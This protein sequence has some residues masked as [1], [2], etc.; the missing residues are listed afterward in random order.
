MK[1]L[2]VAVTSVM[3][4]TLSYSVFAEQDSALAAKKEECF[5]TH[6]RL[7]DKPA[8]KNERTCWQAH[9]YLMQRS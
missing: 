6:A 3:V 8:V 2:L 1:S 5:R 9:A 4:L 7:M